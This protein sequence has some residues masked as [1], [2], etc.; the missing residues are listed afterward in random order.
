MFFMFQPPVPLRLMLVI[1]LL[2]LKVAVSLLLV[3]LPPGQVAMPVLQL[4]SDPVASQFP[5]VGEAS[6]VALAAPAPCGSRVSAAK[7]ANDCK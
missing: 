2:L 1:E 3:L 7:I 5:S 4:F 6:Q